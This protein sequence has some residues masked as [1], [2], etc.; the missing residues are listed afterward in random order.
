MFVTEVKIC[1]VQ[2]EVNVYKDNNRFYSLLI[3]SE[4]IKLFN[5]SIMFGVGFAE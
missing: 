3:F 2:L 4:I 5:V 1:D